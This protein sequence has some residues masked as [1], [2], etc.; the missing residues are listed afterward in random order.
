MLQS[1][2]FHVNTPDKHLGFALVHRRLCVKSHQYIQEDR[3]HLENNH[4]L[5]KNIQDLL[6]SPSGHDHLGVLLALD[7]PERRRYL[8][9]NLKHYFH[10]EFHAGWPKFQPFD[11]HF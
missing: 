6:E 4:A 8:S 9:K 10:E 3:L 2:S 5:E 7:F 11:F 1:L